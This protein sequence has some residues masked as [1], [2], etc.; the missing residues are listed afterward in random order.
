MRILFSSLLVIALAWA[1][2]TRADLTMNGRSTVVAMGMQGTGQERVW[3]DGSRIR[4]DMVD[5]GKAYS[6]I[7][8]LEAR[9]VTVIDHSQRLATVFA[10]QQLRQ[11]A[12]ASLDTR[13]MRL[14]VRATGRT[15]ALQ[16]WTCV[17][18]ELRFAVPAEI[19][20]EQLSFEM[21][22]TIW[23]ARQVPEQRAIARVLRHMQEP[24]FFLALPPMARAAPVQA[25]GL[26]EAVR[27]L[28][29]MGLLCAVDVS[30]NY[31]GQGRVAQ[32][33]RKM[34][35]RISLSYHDYSTAPIPP[36]VFEPPAGY[37]VVRQP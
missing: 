21:H 11:Q 25:Q 19:A 16:R 27:R 10:S 34:A 37:Q 35:S 23:L 30:L 4:R 14:E 15:Q 28:A 29:P 5:R 2:A 3:V 18:H 9:Q 36:E 32:L 31:Q 12:D 1:P 24:D 7:F 17:E 8:D 33:S 26:S 22:G 20:G 6:S 13:E